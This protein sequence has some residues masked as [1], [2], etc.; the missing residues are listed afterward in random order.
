MIRRW[1]QRFDID[2]EQLLAMLRISLKVDVRGHRGVTGQRSRKLPPLVISLF[3]YF[4]MGL[5]LAAN[6]VGRAPLF[7][8][9][10]LCVAYAQIMAV[11][12]VLLEFG[13]TL[14]HPEDEAILGHLPLS[15]RTYFWARLLNLFVF[16]TVVGTALTLGPGIVGVFHRSADWFFPLVF[17]PV[18]LLA[19]LASAAFVV[20]IYTGLLRLLPYERF[21]DYMAYLQGVFSFA[22][23]FAYQ[24]IPRMGQ[25]VI[26]GSA[27]ISGPWLWLAPPAWFAG[28]AALLNGHAQPMYWGLGAVALLSTAW[29]FFR[30]FRKIS[31]GFSK[32][33]GRAKTKR[34]DVRSTEKT[35]ER[36]I[37]RTTRWVGR[38]KN[39]ELLA[40]YELTTAMIKHDRQ[41]KMGLY[42]LMGMP[43]AFIALAV[44][45]GEVVN[46]LTVGG[47]A[48]GSF[49]YMT[50][51]FVFFMVHGLIQTVLTSR[52]WEAAWMMQVAPVQAPGKVVRG[53]ALAVLFRCLVPFYLLLMLVYTRFGPWFDAV[54]LGL[55]LGAWGLAFLSVSLITVKDWPFSKPREKGER[56]GRF[57]F[58]L[59][60]APFFVLMTVLFFLIARWPWLLPVAV[61]AG[62]VFY[63][64]FERWAVD[65][66]NRLLI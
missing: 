19:C 48:G 38:F 60:A 62:L 51:F 25:R 34:A 58:L 22:V 26:A 57:L 16:V 36:S 37:H 35:H 27:E 33:I 64:L 31:M 29:L 1:F 61:A 56:S 21:K 44:I 30:A 23:F 12:M 54:K 65:R 18:S 43:L 15:A 63:K 50:F 14:M 66:L 4:A 20:W 41:V 59:F 9:M 47:F 53:M 13:E 8:Y 42:P 24:L 39:P 17:L 6:L 2:T 49:G 55:L 3:F 10:L 5:M 40:G 28:L 52:D 46:P 45:E 7:L 32:R 11:F